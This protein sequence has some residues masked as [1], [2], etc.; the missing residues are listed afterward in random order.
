VGAILGGATPATLSVG[1]AQLRLPGVGWLLVPILLLL[2]VRRR[3]FEARLIL[4]ML[5]LSAVALMVYS[6]RGMTHYGIA[7]LVAF[8]VALD[9]VARQRL[10][11][12][13][14]RRRHGG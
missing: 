3:G 6:G 13:A 12:L 2:F 7:H 10:A 4:F 8:A 1:V 11:A 9:L 14:R 5:P